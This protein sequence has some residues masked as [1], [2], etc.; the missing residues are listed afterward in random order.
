MKLPVIH[1]GY[2]KT[3]STTL[4]R[5][6]FQRHKD[7]LYLGRG[8]SES[9]IDYIDGGIT[10][11]AEI[12]LKFRRD[13]S[14]DREKSRQLIDKYRA[15]ADEAG[16]TLVYSSEY[17]SIDWP[18]E[19]DLSQKVERLAYF[20][21]N[22]AQIIMVTREQCSWLFSFYKELIRQGYTETYQDFIH[23]V[24]QK[25]DRN[26]LPTLNF[27]HVKNLYE[28][29][30]GRDNVH[31]LPLELLHNHP[32]RFAESLSDI[33]DVPISEDA[34]IN[35]E[36]AAFTDNHLNVLRELN[37]RY[38]HTVMAPAMLG[39]HD[40]FASDYYISELG[41]KSAPIRSLVDEQL[42]TALH[43]VARRF[44]AVNHS[45]KQ[46]IPDDL[47][48]QL[49]KYFVDSNIALQEQ[50]DFDLEALGYAVSEKRA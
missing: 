44:D 4:Q 27:A 41:L 16:K 31:V 21:R 3:A 6:V 25:Q 42:R 10:A 12:D 33:L 29:H 34:L 20:F 49:K 17:L 38:P 45:L 23:W 2:P 47:R 32:H 48:E 19:I 35:R 40:F 14:L 22:Q 39:Y 43:D 26:M 37:K 50:V 46:D 5:R 18:N 11:M 28:A 1:I 24:W 8:V 13:A 15:T 36:N 7:I 30:F 9:M